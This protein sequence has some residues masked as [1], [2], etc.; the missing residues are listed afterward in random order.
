MN[1]LV[2]IGY[3]SYRKCYLNISKEDAL[4]RYI[5]EEGELNEMFTVAEYEAANMLEEFI[6]KDSFMAYDIWQ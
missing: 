2:V 4:K 5:E 1:R 6:F 3:M